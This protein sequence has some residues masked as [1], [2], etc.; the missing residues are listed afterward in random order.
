MAKYRNTLQRGNIRFLIFKDGSSYFGVALEFNIVVEAANPQEAF[1]YLNEAA[2]GY[3]ESARKAKLRPQVL[4][5]KPDEEYEKMWRANQDIRLKEKHE[6]I[7]N[8]LPVFS[9]GVLD[10]AIQ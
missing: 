8:S 7:V 1:I 9:S 2:L 10:L 6:K 3:L 5:Q 4:N